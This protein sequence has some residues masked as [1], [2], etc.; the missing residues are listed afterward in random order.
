MWKNTKVQMLLVGVTCAL[1]GWAAASG[2][3]GTLTDKLAG[4]RPAVAAE[5]LAGPEVAAR[6]AGDT[7]E[8][9]V[10]E[11]LVPADAALEIDGEK[12]TSTGGTRTFSTPPLPVGGQFAYTLKATAGGKEVTRK[13]HLR[14]GGTRSFDLRDGFATAAAARPA[15]TVLKG[16]PGKGG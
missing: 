16:K 12:T 7:E 3:L 2:T 13:I 4:P 8:A 11:V 14:H 1:L 15:A 6:G 9:I 5:S 10:F